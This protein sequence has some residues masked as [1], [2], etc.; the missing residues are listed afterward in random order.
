MSPF[1]LSE[2]WEIAFTENFSI[3]N[4]S[5]TRFAYICIKSSREALKL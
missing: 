1:D 2:I 4:F 5:R 3:W